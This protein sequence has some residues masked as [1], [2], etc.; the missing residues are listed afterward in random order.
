[1]NKYLPEFEG[2]KVLLIDDDLTQLKLL[3]GL[4][5]KIGFFVSAFQS[6]VH[7]LMDIEPDNPPDLVIT[8]IYMPEINGWELCRC[9]RSDIM[10]YTK[11][12]P[13]LIISSIF[14][15]DGILKTA[16]EAG[17]DD[18]IE[19]PIDPEKLIFKIH[20]VF[21]RRSKEKVT[22]ILWVGPCSQCSNKSCTVVPTN[23]YMIEHVE[24]TKQAIKSLSEKIMI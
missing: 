24:N 2:K 8:D 13:I 22:H 15:G 19:M 5:K 1:M 21:N 17:A 6:P 18:F 10:P 7:A 11:D 16:H 3:E 23:K 4:L 20:K 9:L 12:I 14:L